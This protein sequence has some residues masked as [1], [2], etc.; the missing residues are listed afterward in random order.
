MQISKHTNNI[1][2]VHSSQKLSVRHA[3][4]VLGLHKLPLNLEERTKY[5]IP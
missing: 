2:F 4:K 5:E 3:E 1:P